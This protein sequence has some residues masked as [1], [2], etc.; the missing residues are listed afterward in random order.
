MAE[1]RA[2][3]GEQGSADTIWT[4]PVR[5]SRGP[6]P[7]RTREQVAQAAV[8]LA[9][10]HGLSA[11]TMRAV[12]GALGTVAASLYRYVASRDE[13]L[14]LMTDAVLAELPPGPDSGGPWLDGLVGRAHQVLGLYRRHRWL[15]D[16][17]LSARALG[18]RAMDHFECCLAILAEVDRSTPLKMEAIAMITGVVTL[19]ARNEA[20]PARPIAPTQ[21]FAT[22]TP[23]RHPH[24]TAALLRPGPPEPRADPFDRA[25]RSLLTGLLG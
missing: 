7:E 3:G 15:L 12:S 21:L 19:F 20:S 22:A 11:V 18:P 10:A 24:L 17:D 23:D 6:Q 16:V 25:L 4:R 8:A 5:G 9:D 13:L 2:A 1:A 14:D